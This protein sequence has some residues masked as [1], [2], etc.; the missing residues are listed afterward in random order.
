MDSERARARLAEERARIERELAG[1]GRPEAAD[2]PEDSGDQ[3]QDLEQDQ[4]D[5]GLRQDLERTLEAIQR[6]ETRL[7]EGTY[8]VSVVSGDPIPDERLEA[9]P[10]ADRKVDE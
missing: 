7:E 3:A 9:L 1:L 2:S 4:T 8:G 5:E 10:W 6:A